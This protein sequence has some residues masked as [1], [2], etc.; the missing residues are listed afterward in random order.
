MS[1]NSLNSDST[2]KKRDSARKLPIT[3][4]GYLISI[5]APLKL[6][7]VPSRHSTGEREKEE[8]TQGLFANYSKTRWA[9]ERNFYFLGVQNLYK[10]KKKLQIQECPYSASMWLLSSG[11]SLWCC[12]PWQTPGMGW[13]A[14][15]EAHLCSKEKTRLKKLNFS[16][17]YGQVNAHFGGKCSLARTSRLDLGIIWPKTWTKLCQGARK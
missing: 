16:A 10:K 6:R 2:F 11:V 1:F 17:N 4:A 12:P 8:R 3:W 7:D 9:A 15:L 13:W 5:K 14:L